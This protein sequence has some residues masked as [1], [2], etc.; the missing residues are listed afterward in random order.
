MHLN[1][2]P[3]SPEETKFEHNNLMLSILSKGDYNSPS[4]FVKF[5]LVAQTAFLDVFP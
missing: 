4:E 1:K 2:I 5:I 3:Y